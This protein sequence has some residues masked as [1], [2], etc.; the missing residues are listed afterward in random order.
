M[1]HRRLTI[2]FIGAGLLLGGILFWSILPPGSAVGQMLGKDQMNKIRALIHGPMPS[3]INPSLL[4]EPQ[5]QGAQLLQRY[6][7]QCHG[8]PGPGKHTAGQWPAVID[9][10]KSRSNMHSRMMGGIKVPSESEYRIV[11]AYLQKYA[12]KPLMSKKLP[13]SNTSAGKSFRATCAQCHALPDPG[14]HT[15]NEWPGVV[16]RMQK[17]IIAMGKTP[18]DKATAREITGFLQRFGRVEERGKGP[19]GQ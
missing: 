19:G 1:K 7:A 5:S 15:T 12:L 4:S 3:G 2:V 11:I 6:C 9:R 18:L 10:M 16:T 17:N 8:L 13:G 14:Q